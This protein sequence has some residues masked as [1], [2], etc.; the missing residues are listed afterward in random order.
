MMSSSPAWQ[1]LVP[2]GAKEVTLLIEN[3][4]DAPLTFRSPRLVSPSPRKASSRM[5]RRRL[6]R[7]CA[8]A[9]V[10]SHAR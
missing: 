8:L 2:Q 5:W 4:G 3:L 10:K 7:V 6:D 9:T 1:P